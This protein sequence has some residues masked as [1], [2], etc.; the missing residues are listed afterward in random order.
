MKLAIAIQ[1]HDRT[2]SGRCQSHNTRQRDPWSQQPQSAWLTKQ[3]RHQVLPWRGERLE[4]ARGLARRKDAV[5]AIELVIQVGN[6]TEW[7][8]PP[9]GQHPHGKPRR[10]PVDLNEL[11]KAAREAVEAEFGA[12]NIVGLDLHTDESS[13]HLHAVVTPIWEGKLQA[14]HW[15]DGP[16]KVA[17]IRKR[18]HATISRRVQCE[19]S[20]GSPGGEPHDPRKAAGQPGGPQV[21]PGILRRLSGALDASTALAEARRRIVELEQRV[22]S[23]FSRL[24]AAERVATDRLAGMDAAHRRASVADK[25]LRDAQAEI[26]RLRVEVERLTPKPE[27]AAKPEPGPKPHGHSASRKRDAPTPG[28]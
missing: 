17:A 25:K 14:K 1:K 6:Q 26:L 23:L 12:G 13:P 16:A 24:K 27:P 20:P 4:A 10:W 5:V 11:S 21:A 2:S 22:Q 19:Y 7:R 9:D 8:D 28:A 18:L 3:G 15:L